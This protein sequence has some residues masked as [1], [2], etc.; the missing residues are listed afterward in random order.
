L[1]TDKL[2]HK[3][4]TAHPA[5]VLKLFEIPDGHEYKADS[6]TLKEIE[7]RRDIVFEKT[8]GDEAI[9][10]EV[11]GYDDAFL[12]HRAIRGKAMYCIQKKFAGRIRIVVIFLELSHYLATTKLSH[13]FDGSDD[14]TFQ[15]AVFIF[16]QKEVSELESLN[17]VR[18]VPL[19]PLCR[20][21]PEQIKATAPQWA[22]SIKTATDLSE[23][24]ARDLIA[25]LGGFIMHRLRDLPLEEV[26]KILGDIKMEDTQA[27]KDLIAIGYRQGVD[28]GSL[29]TLR[30]NLM[31]LLLA[32]LGR[33]EKSWL[34][35]LE[36]VDS[37]TV[38]KAIYRTVLQ[39]KTPKQ[40]RAAFDAALGNGKKAR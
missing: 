11:Q 38:L 15:P 40:V 22:E 6:L 37:V 30:E 2:V 35:Q 25:W 7:D 17:D 4:S 33:V 8:G 36:T 32:K 13:H 1:A 28:L 20:V 16:D 27:G 5:A 21:T 14:L 9:L 24:Q 3:L 18:L 39:A 26:N 10:L 12:Y 23:Q 31:D 34:D 29:Q 19:Y